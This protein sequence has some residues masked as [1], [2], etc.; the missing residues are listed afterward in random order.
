MSDRFRVPLL[1]AQRLKEQR[2]SIPAVLGLAGLPAGFF[3]Q[4]RIFV[5]TDE[6]FRLWRAIGE[7]SK[8]PAVGLKL[9]TKT[10]IERY[11]PTAIAA[12]CSQSFRDALK[13]I[14]RYKQLTC[15]ESAS[16]PRVEN[17]P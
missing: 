1:L 6:F 16:H 10:H 11:D 4:E 3:Q 17:A 9:G 7:A 13:R 14:A 12:L 5:T 8:D 15:P 2:V